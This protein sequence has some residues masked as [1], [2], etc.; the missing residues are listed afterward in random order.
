MLI[1]IHPGQVAGGIPMPPPLLAGSV[2][3]SGA[4]RALIS[5]S[6]LA[7]AVNS[8]GDAL[9]LVDAEGTVVYANKA[10]EDLL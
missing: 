1:D 2:G 5:D 3:E 10:A 9:L 8:A 7:A 6:G 4:E